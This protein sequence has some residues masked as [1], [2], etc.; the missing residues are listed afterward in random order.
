[1]FVTS[2]VCTSLVWL[3][4]IECGQGETIYSAL[5]MPCLILIDCCIDHILM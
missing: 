3:P 4:K 1:M 5:V 2:G